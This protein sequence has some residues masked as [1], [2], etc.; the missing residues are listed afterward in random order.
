MIAEGW[1]KVDNRD[2][3]GGAGWRRA[4]FEADG[5]NVAVSLST[6]KGASVL[7]T[8][9]PLALL[10]VEGP[11]GYESVRAEALNNDPAAPKHL[12]TRYIHRVTLRNAATRAVLTTFQIPM[13]QAGA[14][15]Q[16]V[17]SAAIRARG[18]GGAVAAAAPATGGG[19]A[20]AGAGAAPAGAAAP[21]A[22]EAAT[23]A[24]AAVVSALS[25]RCRRSGLCRRLH[26]AATDSRTFPLLPHP[27]AC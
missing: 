11:F 25:G 17:R 16:A 7:V 19:G 18:V 9:M 26:V 22:A 6:H 12:D 5:E 2:T 20:A 23:S 4:T 8:R 15:I 14:L 24:L 13:P 27:R 3:L 10:T 1:V 21:S